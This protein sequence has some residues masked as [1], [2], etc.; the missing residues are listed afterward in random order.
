LHF[1]LGTA[2]KMESVEIRWPN[3]N[4]E[5]LKDVAGDYIYTLVEGKGIQD[6]TPLPPP[7][8]SPEKGAPH[9]AH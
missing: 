7:S 3:G 5:L 9:G 4:L 6:K 1:G 8:V 2:S